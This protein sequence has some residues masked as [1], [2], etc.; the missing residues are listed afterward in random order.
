MNSLFESVADVIASRFGVDREAITPESTFDD[1]GLDSL[2]QIELV[3]AL[4]KRLGA[5][6]DDEQMAE[7]SQVSEVVAKL[8]E[9][10]VKA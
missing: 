6:I 2:S 10:G 4:R 1:L 5:D 3:T 8:D 7:F 9:I